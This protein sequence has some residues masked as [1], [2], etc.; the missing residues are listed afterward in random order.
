MSTARFVMH[1]G[2]FSTL[3]LAQPEP[4]RPSTGS[5]LGL[6]SAGVFAEHMHVPHVTISVACNSIVFGR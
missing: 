4:D 5:E 6:R 1:T 3:A 2:G